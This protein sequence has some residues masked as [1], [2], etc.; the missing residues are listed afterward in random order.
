MKASEFDLNNLDFQNPGGWPNPVKY[1]FAVLIVVLLAVGGYY[2]LIKRKV[3]ELEAL[4]RTERELVEEFRTK[5]AKVVNLEEYRR[6]LDDMRELLRQM[7]RQLP[8]RT[9]MPDLLV[10]VSQAALATGLD[11]Q[12]FQ[13]QPEVVHEFYAERPISLRM[14]GN[15]H[16]FGEFVSAVAS[17]PRVVILTMHDIALGPSSGAA[18]AGSAPTGQL[19]LEG[20]VKTYRY[21]DDEESALAT[22]EAVDAARGGG[23]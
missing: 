13:P 12:K 7:L 17:L 10:D 20:T 6:Q 1:F 19:V 9:E 18:A 11:N 3:Q 21:V 8:S 16:Q 5:Q 22:G 2:G 14:V 4:E 23:Q 15:Y